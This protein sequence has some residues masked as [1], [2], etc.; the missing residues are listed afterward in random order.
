[1]DPQLA[2]DAVAAAAAQIDLPP[3]SPLALTLSGGYDRYEMYGWLRRQ[4]PGWSP[5]ELSRLGAMMP[6]AI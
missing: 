1:M 3:S 2:S 5:R 4:G 6:P